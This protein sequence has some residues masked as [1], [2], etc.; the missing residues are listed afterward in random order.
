MTSDW[1]D[2]IH[3]EDCRIG[4]D[5]IPD[6]S[7]DLVVMDPP[8]LLETRGGGTFGSA[9]RTYHSELGPI[10]DGID[11]SLLYKISRKL[12][13]NNKADKERFGHPTV[14]PLEIVRNIIGNSAPRGG[15]PSDP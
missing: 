13:A 12:S 3:C 14:K 1:I 4:L 10:S 5:R 9:N 8:Y 11:S 15:G 2:T 6:G 7:I